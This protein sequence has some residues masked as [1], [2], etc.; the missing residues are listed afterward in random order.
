MP[1]GDNRKI[2]PNR[3]I[4]KTFSDRF[5]DRWNAQDID[6]M[7]LFSKNE[8]VC[9][10]WNSHD[11]VE[12]GMSDKDIFYLTLPSDVE[13]IGEASRIKQDSITQQKTRRTIS[14]KFCA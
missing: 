5:D 14:R 8:V 2:R 9:K 7:L 1:I 12:V 10:K 6:P 4:Q 13:N 3:P 11:V